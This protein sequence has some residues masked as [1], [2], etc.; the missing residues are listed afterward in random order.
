MLP[1]KSIRVDF[2][3]DFEAKRTVFKYRL[4]SGGN[5]I[6]DYLRKSCRVGYVMVCPIFA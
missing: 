2:L 5:V 4:D 1:F 6:V 3:P